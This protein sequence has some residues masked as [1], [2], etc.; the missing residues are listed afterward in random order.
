MRA[1][2][3]SSGLAALAAIWGLLPLLALPPFSAHML[4]HMGLVALA[5]P[6][7][8]AGLA[9]T[10]LDPVPRA[11]LLFG[12]LAASLGELVVVWAWH[13]PALH[14]LA[15]HSPAPWLLEQASFLAVGLWLWMAALGGGEEL[16]RQ[17]AVQGVVGLLFTS[18][19]MT[20]LGALLGLAQRPLYGHG[21]VLDQQV[22]GAIM[23]LVGGA[24]YL[25]GAL[26]LT[27]LLLRERSP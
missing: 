24:S 11:P 7:L 4:A 20:L 10:R 9:G 1:A 15:R 22:G 3:T 23:L 19:H 17:R 6:L 21:T 8:A 5:S 16:R 26:G 27:G 2:L 13:A 25:V 12:A 18:M 14:H